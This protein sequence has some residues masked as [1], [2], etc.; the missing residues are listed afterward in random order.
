MKRP[1]QQPAIWT[2]LACRS[3]KGPLACSRLL[4]INA[5]R[6]RHCDLDNREGRKFCAKCGAALGWACAACGFAN[7]AGDRFCGGCG[8]PAGDTIAAPPVPADAAA[9]GEG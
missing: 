8:K 5:M 4:G 3:D 9:D 6:C 1:R 2:A 7:E